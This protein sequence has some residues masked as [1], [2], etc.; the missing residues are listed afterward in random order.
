M[1]ADLN[2]KITVEDC[3]RDAEEKLIAAKVYFGHGADN[4]TDEAI[5][6]IWY[7]LKLPVDADDAILQRLVST[8]ELAQI[9]SMVST[10]ISKRKPLAYLTHEAWFMGLPF[11]VDERVLIPRSPFAELIANQFQPWVNPSNG[12]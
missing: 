3:I 1:Q 9:N 8:A 11:H 6:L 4:A 5:R 2:D 7:C 10:R 12:S